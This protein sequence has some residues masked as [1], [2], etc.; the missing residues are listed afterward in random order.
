MYDGSDGPRGGK[1]PV[2]FYLFRRELKIFLGF[3]CSVKFVGI[4]NEFC[5]LRFLGTNRYKRGTI[6]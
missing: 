2:E 3:F 6:R 1:K 5:G 4:W